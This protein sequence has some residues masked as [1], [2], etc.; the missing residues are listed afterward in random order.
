[1]VGE[2]GLFGEFRGEVVGCRLQ[3]K[4]IREA[5][6]GEREVVDRKGSY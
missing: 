2:G 5:R 6:D 3:G 4:Y 1:M